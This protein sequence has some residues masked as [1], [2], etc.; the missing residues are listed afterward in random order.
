MRHEGFSKAGSVRTST[1][2]AIGLS[3]TAI[4]VSTLEILESRST[5]IL[6]AVECLKMGQ[7]TCA[8]DSNENIGS[9]KKGK[10][11]FGT[12]NIGNENIGNANVSTANWGNNNNGTGNRCFNKHGKRKP[13]S[14]P[15]E[16]GPSSAK[17][18]TFSQPTSFATSHPSTKPIASISTTTCIRHTTVERSYRWEVQRHV[19]FYHAFGFISGSV[20]RAD[21]TFTFSVTLG[22]VVP[23]ALFYA[24][25]TTDGTVVQNIMSQDTGNPS[26]M[27]LKLDASVVPFVAYAQVVA[28]KFSGG[29]SNALTLK[30]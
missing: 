19:C 23:D 16:K 11:N 21:Q 7:K 4:R 27:V 17:T 8:A 28:L 10:N 9:G 3:M 1:L 29:S 25:F 15:A 24:F 6:L 20:T 14:P 18:L 12:S 5:N 30:L 26:T 2:D 13:L 22:S